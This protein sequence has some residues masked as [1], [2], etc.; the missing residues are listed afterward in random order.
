MGA[1]LLLGCASP[2]VLTTQASQ[3]ELVVAGNKKNVM[4][5]LISEVR[6]A[7]FRVRTWTDDDLVFCDPPDESIATGIL[8][9]LVLS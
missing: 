7:S 2:S 8:S 3:P 9:I 4:T 5:A 6:T 1:T